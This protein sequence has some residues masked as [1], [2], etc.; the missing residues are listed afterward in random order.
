MRLLTEEQRRDLSY[1]IFQQG[2]G[3]SMNQIMMVVDYMLMSQKEKWKESLIKDITFMAQPYEDSK[4]RNPL[5]LESI[6][7][8][9]NKE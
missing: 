8:R 9:I 7:N 2:N 1:L 5:R 3:V 4:W 6:I